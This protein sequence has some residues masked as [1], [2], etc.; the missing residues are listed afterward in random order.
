LLVG[1]R[2]SFSVETHQPRR[3]FDESFISPK[4]FPPVL[5]RKAKIASPV[6][7][8]Q[9]LLFDQLIEQAARATL[10]RSSKFQ[11][12]VAVKLDAIIGYGSV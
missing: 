7:C 11:L 2:R 8:P 10:N 5:A 1:S 6:A 4:L 3:V 12:L 9:T